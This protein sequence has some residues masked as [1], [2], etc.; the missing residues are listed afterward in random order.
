MIELIALE[1]CHQ[2]AGT[3]VAAAGRELAVFRLAD[4]ERVMVTDNSCPHS[5]GN[6]SGGALDGEVVT[7]PWH[8][9]KFDV[10]SG[11][12]VHSTQVRLRTYP[13]VVR[14][15]VVWVDLSREH[16]EDAAAKCAGA[17]SSAVR[18]DD[19]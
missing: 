13:S 11:A 15:G 19:S 18:A 12:C 8:Q 16:A 1:K 6:L 7:C 10:S 2:N 9:W 4:S 5:S 17:C 14:E 3:F